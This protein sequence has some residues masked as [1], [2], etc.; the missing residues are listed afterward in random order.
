MKPDPICSNKDIKQQA[1]LAKYR[2]E[3][4]V[5]KP[6]EELDNTDLLNMGHLNEFLDEC[7]RKKILDEYRKKK[8]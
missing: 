6:I 4:I 7:E 3:N 8:E 5:Q 1:K 2:L